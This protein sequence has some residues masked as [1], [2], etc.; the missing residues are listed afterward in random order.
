MH[1]SIVHGRET[2]GSEP[3]KYLQEKKS[4]EIPIV[5]ASEVG[6]AQTGWGNPSGV[7]GRERGSPREVRKPEVSGK[8]W[9][10]LPET[11]KARYAKTGGLHGSRS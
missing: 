6:R 11:V 10:G 8:V 4:K 3:S 9:E 7:V 1:E 5:A 2:Q